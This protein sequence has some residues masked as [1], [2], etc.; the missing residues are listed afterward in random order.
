MGEDK[1]PNNTTP[2]EAVDPQDKPE[3]ESIMMGPLTQEQQ[4]FFTQAQ[5]ALDY[6]ILS[7]NDLAKDHSG[8]LLKAQIADR[9]LGDTWK[10]EP[11]QNREK[12]TEG[13]LW[14]I[15]LS[16]YSPAGQ[17]MTK[18][19]QIETQAETI[20]ASSVP[21]KFRR[22]FSPNEI[23]ETLHESQAAVTIS[24]KLKETCKRIFSDPDQE[25]QKES[26]ELEASK[27]AVPNADSAKNKKERS[28]IIHAEENFS[29]RLDNI[30]SQ[31]QIDT[32]HLTEKNS[33]YYAVLEENLKDLARM[34]TQTDY[35]H[36]YLDAAIVL[37]KV[38]SQLA[39]TGFDFTKDYTKESGIVYKSTLS[40]KQKMK[41]LPPQIKDLWGESYEYIDYD[42]RPEFFG[43]L[44]KGLP[45]KLEE[46]SL[47]PKK[48]KYKHLRE[49]WQA[50]PFIHRI[51]FIPYVRMLNKEE[52]K[53][54]RE[55]HGR[56]K[57]PHESF[58]A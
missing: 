19:A 45:L 2:P 53:S 58:W 12:G 56:R 8:F 26:P 42:D 20:I 4:N 3:A 24:E 10:K 57:W 5:R 28:K 39:K 6:R 29:E 34:G 27:E 49:Q 47:L 32:T 22:R 43:A 51:T 33:K 23:Q 41:I 37:F 13:Q 46:N 7:P 21:N 36:Y 35:P 11:L 55:E 1:V 16:E 18:L 14:N 31:F 17:S 44:F 54:Y 50:E 25:P 52:T 30:I 40:H 15:L 48:E 9:L 38:I